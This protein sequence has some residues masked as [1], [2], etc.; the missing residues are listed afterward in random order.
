MLDLPSRVYL[1][2][3][4]LVGRIVTSHAVSPTQCAY[5]DVM[6]DCR[7]LSLQSVADVSNLLQPE[8]EELDLG[9]NV[10]ISAFKRTSFPLLTR[11]WGRNI[12]IQYY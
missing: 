10:E 4:L 5:H 8:V 3:L 7:F 2:V 12:L 1:L 11:L 6:V 9:D